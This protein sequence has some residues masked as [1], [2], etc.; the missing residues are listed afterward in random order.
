M[1][2]LM[3]LQKGLQVPFVFEQFSGIRSALMYVSAYTV[4]KAG[5]IETEVAKS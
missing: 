1:H 2:D 5:V 4:R 3:L